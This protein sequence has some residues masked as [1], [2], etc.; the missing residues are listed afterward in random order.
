MKILDKLFRNESTPEA[1]KIWKDV[2]NAAAKAPDWLR[3]KI[4]N[5]PINIKNKKEIDTNKY[6]DIRDYLPNDCQDCMLVS[7]KYMIA[8]NEMLRELL[9]DAYECLSKGKQKG[10]D[11]LISG[12]WAVKIF[13]NVEKIMKEE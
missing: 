4:E 7:S 9:F 12:D 1:R 13:N 10:S 5:A 6:I 8:E 3:E 11:I 2:E